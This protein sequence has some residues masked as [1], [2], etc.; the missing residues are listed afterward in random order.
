MTTANEELKSTVRNWITSRIRSTNDD[1]LA[2]ND[3]V[4]FHRIEEESES[5]GVYSTILKD[6][7]TSGQIEFVDTL[8]ASEYG[9]RRI[10]FTDTSGENIIPFNFDGNGFVE[11]VPFTDESDAEMAELLE[12]FL[13][14]ELND[15]IAQ[16]KANDPENADKYD[17]MELI[18]DIKVFNPITPDKRLQV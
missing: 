18:C 1:Y 8:D 10:A 14:G 13:E 11:S 16:L 2:S 12:R 9:G 3:Y 6:T 17:A 15:T 5:S 7:D 4:K